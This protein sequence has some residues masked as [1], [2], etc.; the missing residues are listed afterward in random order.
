[1]GRGKGQNKRI[2]KEERRKGKI[3]GTVEEK[4]EDEEEHSKRCG[5]L[6][7]DKSE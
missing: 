1:M 7:R 4:R 5:G 3:E 2:G 6:M